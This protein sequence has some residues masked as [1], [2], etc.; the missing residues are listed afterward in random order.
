VAVWLGCGC[1]VKNNVEIKLPARQQH[2][3]SHRVLAQHVVEP[4]QS[5]AGDDRNGMVKTVFV[6]GLGFIGAN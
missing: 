4:Q 5:I 6:Y 1:G 3:T 2:K